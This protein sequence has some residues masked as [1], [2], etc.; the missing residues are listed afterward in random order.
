MKLYNSKLIEIIPSIN[1]RTFEEVQERVRRVESHVKW[2]HLDVTDGIFSKYLTWHDPRDL[3]NLRTFDVIKFEVHLMLSEPEKV[4]DQWLVRPIER[5]IVHL[6]AVRDMDLIIKKCREA[7]VEIGLSLKPETFW[8]NLKPWFD[9]V[10][11]I[12]ALEVHPGPSSQPMAEDAFEKISSIHKACPECIIEVDGGINPE[13]AKK[14]VEA[15]ANLLV[16]G[17]YIFDS[18]DIKQAIE[19]LRGSISQGS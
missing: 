3:S 10:D 18:Q 12:S 2:C 8:G 11:M 4:I 13:T 16:A 1:V 15:G 7:G 17:A 5:I 19:T 14:S 9:K 6:E